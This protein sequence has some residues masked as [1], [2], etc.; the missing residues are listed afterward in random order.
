[1]CIR[2]RRGIDKLELNKDDKVSRGENYNNINKSMILE[3]DYVDRGSD[4]LLYTS[5]VS[6]EAWIYLKT[7]QLSFCNNV[8]LVMNMD[9]SLCQRQCNNS[10]NF[11]E[12]GESTSKK[13]KNIPSVGKKMARFFNLQDAV[14]I[15][16]Y[17]KAKP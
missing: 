6:Q 16:I 4:C 9:S 3:N 7:I 2:D 15:T 13:S 14:L 11:L 10:N 12:V 17:K 8:L 5:N 1:M